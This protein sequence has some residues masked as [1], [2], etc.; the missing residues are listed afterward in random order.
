MGKAHPFLRIAAGLF[1]TS[2]LLGALAGESTGIV[3]VQVI[4]G[5]AAWCFLIV[6]FVRY[7]RGE[8]GLR[9]S[10]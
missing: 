9:V 6:W 8:A 3:A 1:L 4:V 5:V 10:R 2:G 7:R